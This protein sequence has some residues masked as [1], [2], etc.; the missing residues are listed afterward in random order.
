MKTTR[1]PP[2]TCTQC[3]S[4]NNAASSSADV[5][6]PGDV[7]ICGKCGIL[8]IFDEGLTLRPPT[9][10]ELAALQADPIWEQVE[11]MQEALLE[12]GKKR[13]Q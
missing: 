13:E 12:F 2:H 1:V 9:A 10:D 11:A 7:S 4:V 6:S 8:T 3:G 5:P